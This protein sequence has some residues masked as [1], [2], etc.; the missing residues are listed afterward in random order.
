MP[1][2]SAPLILFAIS[3]M[4][5]IIIGEKQIVPVYIYI[6]PIILFLFLTL[7]KKWLFLTALSFY[8]TFLGIFRIQLMKYY[9][10]DDIIFLQGEKVKLRAQISSYPERRK[11]CYIF[12]ATK[13]K[14]WQ[15]MWK[16]KKG[17]LIITTC[18]QK[19]LSYGDIIET[20]GRIIIKKGRIYFKAKN[21]KI[22]G[23]GKWLNPF[24]ILIFKIK[25]KTSQL[26]EKLFPSEYAQFLKALL[27]GEKK[28]LDWHL[29]EKFIHSG[30]AHILA[31]SGLHVGLFYF[32]CNVV[33]KALHIYGRKRNI[34]TIIIILLYMS[35]TGS[36]IPVVRATI[37][38]VFYLLA[39]YFYREVNIYNLLSLSSILILF[40]NP[41]SIY[42]ASF[43]LS[44]IAV[45]GI[46]SIFTIFPSY[47]MLLDTKLKIL[48]HWLLNAAKASLAAWLAVFPLICYYWGYITPYAVLTNLIIIPIV[49]LII[50]QSFLILITGLISVNLANILSYS[51]YILIYLL[52]LILDK[53][54][55]LPY[56]YIKIA[57]F[58]LQGLFIYYSCII[59]LYI[60]LL[61][62]TISR[63]FDKIR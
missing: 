38:M 30:N 11:Q 12:T 54:L 32:I 8:A 42:E 17:K 49:S 25:R 18:S 13:L 60:Y 44:F 61:K 35:L 21:L 4:I 39:N 6:L 58:S 63:Y 46:V 19:T 56:S 43:Q 51:C 48:K 24:K 20:E 62:R 23:K 27:L 33:L 57:N 15:G 37:V 16:E 14:I 10:P 31:I 1:P 59:F 52:F 5:G 29:K 40:I 2:F 3:F 26:L 55:S 45:L 34:I 50:A 47:H 36:R 53:I 9:S 7:N 28:S 41:L 22:K